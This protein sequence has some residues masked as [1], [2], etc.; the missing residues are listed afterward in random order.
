M[1]LNQHKQSKA[2]N[3]LIVHDGSVINFDHV[4]DFKKDCD[5]GIVFFMDVPHPTTNEAQSKI[6]MHLESTEK[7]DEAF[8]TILDYYDGDVVRI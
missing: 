1:N 4:T 5:N 2:V 8:E 7:R 3:M 6:T